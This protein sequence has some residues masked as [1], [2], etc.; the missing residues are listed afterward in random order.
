MLKQRMAYF[1]IEYA[2]GA[3]IP[4]NNGRR[5]SFST[6]DAT[7]VALASASDRTGL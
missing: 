1:T 5:L 3:E 2:E 4:D 7:A 6:L